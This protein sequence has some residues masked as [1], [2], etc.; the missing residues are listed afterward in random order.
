MASAC[1]VAARLKAAYRGNVSAQKALKYDQWPGCLSVAIIPKYH[2]YYALSS[3]FRLAR[4][5]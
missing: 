1:N 3:S 4:G 2:V 5:G